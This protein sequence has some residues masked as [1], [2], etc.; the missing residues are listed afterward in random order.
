MIVYKLY[1]KKFGWGWGKN[2][3][4]YVQKQD[5]YNIK[6]LETTIIGMYLPSEITL[7]NLGKIEKIELVKS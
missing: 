7:F 3:P 2:Q 6:T 4:K 5:S 1:T